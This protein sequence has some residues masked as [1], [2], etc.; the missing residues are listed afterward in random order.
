ML[1]PYFQE[2]AFIPATDRP[3]AQSAGHA[4]Q[5]CAGR[6][7]KANENK[8]LEACARRCSM[9]VEMRPAMA[10]HLGDD[11]VSTNGSS[12]TNSSA[13]SRERNTAIEPSRGA[14]QA[15]GEQVLLRGECVDALLVRRKV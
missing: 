3:F 8:R 13:A 7:P 12:R 6:P 9:C 14:E 15:D 5:P 2:Y 1:A 4:K 10:H 11:T